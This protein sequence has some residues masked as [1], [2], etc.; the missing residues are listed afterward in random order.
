MK[1]VTL[2]THSIYSDGVKT[3]E[4]VVQLAIDA[5]IELISLTD[6]N[7]MDGYPRFIEAC[8]KHDLKYIKGVEI[9]CIQ[10]EIGFHQELLAYFP[11]G[12]EEC[13]DNI[14]IH[15][16]LSRRER[17]IR[18]LGILKTHFNINLH[19][20][21][22]EEMEIEEKGFFSFLSN[23]LVYRYMTTKNELLPSYL[24]MQ[25]LDIWKKAWKRT[26][27]DT[28]YPLYE[29]IETISKGGGFTSLAHFG[30]HFGAN[31]ELMRQKSDEYIE[32]LRYMKSIGLWGIELHPYRYKPQR[33]EINEIIK[34]WAAVSNLNHTVGS[35]YHGTNMS[36]HKIYEYLNYDFMGF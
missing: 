29:L 14:L 17:V 31:T 32:H 33:D 10:A 36:P 5:G 28:K 18:A 1:K 15:K 34:E 22:L 13:L 19:I 4:E 11:N 16:Q 25:E 7:T 8:E 2:H 23:R 3:P 21:E 26:Y 6:H 12:G 9:D 24:E 20:S 30:F 27:N 35:D